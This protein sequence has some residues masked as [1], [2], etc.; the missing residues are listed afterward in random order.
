MVFLARFAGTPTQLAAKGASWDP[1][2]RGHMSGVEPVEGVSEVEH[3]SSACMGKGEMSMVNL[4]KPWPRPS[5]A[6]AVVYVLRPAVALA[7][8]I[9]LEYSNPS[10]ELDRMMY[11][12]RTSKAPRV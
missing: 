10:Q 8:E 1:G 9:C 2:D 11:N 4:K 3:P 7:W 5:Q 6:R 12:K